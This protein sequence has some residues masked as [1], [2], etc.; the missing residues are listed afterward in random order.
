[1]C[2][3]AAQQDAVTEPAVAD[4]SSRAAAAAAVSDGLSDKSR[5]V[6]NVGDDDVSLS[7]AAEMMVRDV[8]AVSDAAADGGDAVK[9]STPKYQ[10]LDALSTATPTLIHKSASKYASHT[11]TVISFSYPE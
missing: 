9:L 7:S 11:H 10:L 8:Q 4:S 6:F 5:P 2:L 1:M 3:S